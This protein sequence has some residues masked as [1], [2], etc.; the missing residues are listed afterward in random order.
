MS[1]H[2]LRNCVVITAC[3][4]NG[5]LHSVE[6]TWLRIDAKAYRACTGKNDIPH[7]QFCCLQ[8]LSVVDIFASSPWYFRFSHSNGPK[9]SCSISGRSN[10]KVVAVVQTLHGLQAPVDWDDFCGLSQCLSKCLLGLAI[11]LTSSRQVCCKNMSPLVYATL[12]RST[13]IL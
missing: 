3:V 5:L 7:S 4:F 12:C 8:L 11:S 9:G 1:L 13:V 2:H 6:N 10:C